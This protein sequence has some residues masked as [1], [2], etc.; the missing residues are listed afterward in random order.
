MIDLVKMKALV[1]PAN[2]DEKDLGAT[3]NIE[4]IPED[5]VAEAEEYRSELMDVLSLIDED[6]MERYLGDEDITED[7]LKAVIR[8]GTL[9]GEIVPILNGTAFKNKGVQPLL[10]AVVN[11][12][13]SPLD[14]PPVEGTHPRS[15]EPETR[16]ADDD[17]PFSALAL[18]LIHI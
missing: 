7:E 8:K 5:M 1:W 4:D 2:V 3:F 16:D 14:L 18:S 15:G 11:Y 13:P 17:A 10:D 9:S 12:M 6:L